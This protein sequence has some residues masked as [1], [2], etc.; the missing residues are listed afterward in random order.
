[1]KEKILKQEKTE[2]V[3]NIS[4]NTITENIY[5]LAS[6]LGDIETIDAAVL[7]IEEK[8]QEILYNIIMAIHFQST[9]LQTNET[10]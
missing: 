7:G 1:M 3:E 9:H 5:H 4:Q 6:A 10:A 8:K 2:T